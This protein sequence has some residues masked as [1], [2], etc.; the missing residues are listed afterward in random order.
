MERE[1][2]INEQAIWGVVSETEGQ[3]ALVLFGCA[4]K[5]TTESYPSLSVYQASQC[6]GFYWNR[7]STIL[8][9]AGLRNK[10]QWKCPSDLR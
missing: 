9:V 4:F 10:Y 1:H 2:K 6:W 5:S 8:S 3:Q 7:F